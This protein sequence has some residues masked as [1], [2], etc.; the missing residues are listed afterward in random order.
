TS[1]SPAQAGINQK[2]FNDNAYPGTKPWEQLGGNTA[3]QTP[4]NVAREQR[5]TAQKLQKPQLR[6]SLEIARMNARSAAV[7]AGSQW[8]PEAVVKLGDYAARGKSPKHLTRP[9][10]QRQA[11]AAAENAA[12]N[13]QNILE[14]RKKTEILSL[15]LQLEREKHNLNIGHVLKDPVVA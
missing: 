5:R 13:W 6:T 2:S 1:I 10:P 15:S 4:V 3:S 14:T 9:A 7:S 11:G 12:T 8:G